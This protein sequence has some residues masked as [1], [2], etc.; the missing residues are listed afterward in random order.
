VEGLGG[1]TDTLGL[2][3]VQEQASA[4]LWQV[5]SERPYDTMQF[6]LKTHCEKH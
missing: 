2:D 3:V 5:F 1:T 4:K 6:E